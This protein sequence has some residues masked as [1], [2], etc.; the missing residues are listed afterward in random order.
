[1]LIFQQETMKPEAMDIVRLPEGDIEP[2]LCLRGL[3]PCGRS[4]LPL[5]ENNLRRR[6]HL[7]LSRDAKAFLLETFGM[8][9]FYAL[10]TTRFWK[11][12]AVWVAMVS[13]DEFHAL[14]WELRGCHC[15]DAVANPIFLSQPRVQWMT[16]PAQWVWLAL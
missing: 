4:Y 3:S 14:G 1:M 13:Q 16:A 2:S 9:C 7:G 11:E 12:V 15:E 10:R 8:V 5:L 6:I